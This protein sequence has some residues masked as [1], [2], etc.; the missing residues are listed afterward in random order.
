MK[1]V[2]FSDAPIEYNNEEASA[3]V[4][5]Y[6]AAIA[7]LTPKGDDWKKRYCELFISLKEL[8]TFF[9]KGSPLTEIMDKIIQE[10]DPQLPQSSTGE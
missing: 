7:S 10:Y 9:R 2:K 1:E 8:R 5:G 6:N 4:S 3:W